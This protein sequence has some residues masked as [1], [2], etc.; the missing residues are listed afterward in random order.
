MST[1]P[2]DRRRNDEETTSGGL[3]VFLWVAAVLAAQLALIGWLAERL[4]SAY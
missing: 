2:S 1:S 4:Y 3:T